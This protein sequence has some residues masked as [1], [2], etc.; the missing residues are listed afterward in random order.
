M[1]REGRQI[2]IVL[3]GV[4]S[5]G[6]S[7]TAKAV[8]ALS[9]VPLLH[10][11]MDG[12]LDMLPE[13]L[14]GHPDGIVFNASEVEGHR[15]VEV[16]T[17]PVCDRLMSG[18]RHAVAAMAAEGNSLI[19][20]DVMLGHE[21]VEYRALLSGHDLRFVRLNVP[22]NV[23]E[24]R[25]RQRGDREIGLARAQY[26]IVARG[27]GYDLEL[28]AGANTPAQNAERICAAFGL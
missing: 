10:V 4:G 12:F 7:S 15:V 13:G 24:A 14:I 2:I 28:D 20:D 18:M 5:A 16:E 17:G 25:E 6:K 1:M 3:N 23:L 9:S 11:S 19:V 26:D 8:Q 21:M 27:Q 22:L